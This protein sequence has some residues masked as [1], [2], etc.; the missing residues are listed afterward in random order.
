MLFVWILNGKK[1]KHTAFIVVAAFFAALVAFVQS[2]S[3]AV[4]STSQGPKALSKVQTNK[5]QVALTFDIGWGEARV[6]PILK[7]LK[8]ENINATF[9]VTGEWVD[10]HPNLIDKIKKADLEIASHGMKHNTYTSMET[11]D[12]KNDILQA[13]QMINKISG[14]SP[15]FLRPPKGKINKDV[16]NVA[17]KLN[18]DVVLWSV[19]PQDTANPGH[20][21]IAA[22]V[23]NHTQKGDIIR[24]HASDSAKQT[25]NA[26]P[27]IIEGLQDKGLKM[28]SLS[29]LVSDAKVKSKTLE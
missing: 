29:K 19:N 4:F 10:A 17:N 23:L 13:K 28:V 1:A 7:F 21:K 3:V 27:L 14:D 6:K 5:Q 26:L 15:T 2:E 8:K 16:L 22:Y 9:F 18:Q 20:K 12:I 24:L 11:N 25:L